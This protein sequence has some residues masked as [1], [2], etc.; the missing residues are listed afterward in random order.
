VH[1][2]FVPFVI[3]EVKNLLCVLVS[4]REK[5]EGSSQRHRVTVKILSLNLPHFG[6]RLFT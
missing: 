4:L 2:I 5:K 1:N 3:F 6:V